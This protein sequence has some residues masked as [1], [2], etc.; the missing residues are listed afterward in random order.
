VTSAT[1]AIRQ[2]IESGTIVALG[3]SGTIVGPQRVND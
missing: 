1:F 3:E 2:S